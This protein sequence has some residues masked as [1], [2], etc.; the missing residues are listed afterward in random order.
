[1]PEPRQDGYDN[2]NWSSFQMFFQGWILRQQHYLDQLV[3]STDKPEEE[4]ITL[5]SQVLSHYQQYY[6]AKSIVIRQ[7]VYVVFTPPWFSSFERTFLWIAGFKPGLA[8][9]ILNNSVRDSLSEDQKEQV[10]E[11]M[12]ETRVAEKELSDE[13]ARIQE[14]VVAPP[15]VGMARLMRHN[16]NTESDREHRDEVDMGLRSLRETMEALVESA[17]FVRMTTARK[18]VEMLSPG[19]AVIF[20][21]AATQLQLKVREMG[22]QRE[23]ELRRRARS[24]ATT[25]RRT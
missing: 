17:D 22:Y 7:D 16:S 2:A 9:K 3:T 24:R 20:L 10:R 11:L 19:Q 6:E 1:M 8:F 13:H 4:L 23:A 14:R 15:V 12:F 18:V 5:V 25:T 21:A